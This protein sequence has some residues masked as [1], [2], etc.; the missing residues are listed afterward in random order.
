[1]KDLLSI[2]EDLYGLGLLFG[3]LRKGCLKRQNILILYNEWKARFDF[4]IVLPDYATCA[5]YS[6]QYFGTS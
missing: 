3:N 5:C 1:M 6:S 2:V 4:E